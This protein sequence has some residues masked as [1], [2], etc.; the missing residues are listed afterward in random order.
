[1]GGL[2]DAYCVADT[3]TKEFYAFV[4]EWKATA[5]EAKIPTTT[6]SDVLGTQTAASLY[7]TPSLGAN[8]KKPSSASHVKEHPKIALAIFCT[9][10]VLNVVSI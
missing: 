5:A 1:V 8:S 4:N 10:A 7:Y 2:A 6:A 9:L 3:P